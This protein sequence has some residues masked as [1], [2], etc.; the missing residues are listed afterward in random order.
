MSIS[1]ALKA[2]NEAD[3]K[4]TYK[5]LIFCLANNAISSLNNFELNIAVSNYAND[6]QFISYGE[7]TVWVGGYEYQSPHPFTLRVI[8]T[9]NMEK[10]KTRIAQLGQFT[11]V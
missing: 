2:T 3:R 8:L 5:Q 7:I 4:P 6:C 9:N 11:H 1:V 10:I